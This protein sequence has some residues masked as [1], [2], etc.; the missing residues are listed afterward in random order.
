MRFA[1]LML[2]VFMAQAVMVPAPALAESEVRIYWSVGIMIGGL[3]I[4]ATFSSGDM[5]KKETETDYAEAGKSGE[6]AARIAKAIVK[7]AKT[8]PRQYTTPGTLTVFSW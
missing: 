7:D 4:F 3:S 6:E 8:S 5:S 2:I 1:A